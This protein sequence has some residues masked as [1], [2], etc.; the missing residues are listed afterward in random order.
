[1]MLMGARKAKPGSTNR[2]IPSRHRGP[3]RIGSTIL[4][5]LSCILD[6]THKAYEQ[7]CYIL[8]AVGLRTALDNCIAAVG[9]DP[10]V[11]FEEKLKALRDE[12][13][14]GET[15][16]GLLEVLTNA[17]NA[18]A[19]RGW[20]PQQQEIVH[21]LDVLETFIQRVLVNGK[22]VLAMTD[23]IPRKPKRQKKSVP[24]DAAIPEPMAK[25]K[26]ENG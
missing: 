24:Q 12:G 15:E 14:I 11:S 3:D 2:P 10:A 26:S 4:G 5:P 21:L 18:A 1:M 23:G 25:P 20:S 7:G 16:H 19:H 17:G 8:A 9:I 13:F 22:R 6:E